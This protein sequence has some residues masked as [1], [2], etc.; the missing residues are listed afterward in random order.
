MPLN[1][2]WGVIYELHVSPI[3]RPAFYL[4][5]FLSA[6]PKTFMNFNELEHDV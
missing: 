4:Q 5:T 3:L 2:V 1:K 6:S